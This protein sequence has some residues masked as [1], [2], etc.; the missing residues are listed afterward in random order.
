MSG[1]DLDVASWLT[2]DFLEGYVSWREESATVR[3]AY[4]LWQDAQ[5]QDQSVAF[6]A[7]GAA[8]DREE[9]AARALRRRVERI[10]APLEPRE[11]VNASSG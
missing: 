6:A 4:A 9:Q 2:D 1:Q 3:N 11:L 5:P 8:L 10:R 7:Y